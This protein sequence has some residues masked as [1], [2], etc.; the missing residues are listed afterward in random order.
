MTDP[1][2]LLGLDRTATEA[3]VGETRRRLAR[4]SHPD[5]G[6][7]V[8]AMQ[9]INAAAD[10]V[11]AALR[12]GSSSPSALRPT[13]KAQRHAPGRQRERQGQPW[14]D[15]AVDHPSFTIEALPVDAFEALML[16]GSEL[17]TIVDDDQP[18]RL[19]F[20][21]EGDLRAW[22]EV[23]LV[24]DAG[25]TTASVAVAAEPGYPRPTV[26]QVRDLLVE[27]LNRLDWA[28]GPNQPPP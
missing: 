11:L 3:E 13:G 18:Y 1:W 28:D 8:T 5:L 12:A 16:V 23:T 25:S 2:A 24:P 15:S 21:L 9:A 19:E 27:G 4:E 17:G 14:R 10:Q 20:R 6:G 22:C 7:D 26:E